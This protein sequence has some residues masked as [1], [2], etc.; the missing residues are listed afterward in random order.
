MLL[1]AVVSV[2]LVPAAGAADDQWLTDAERQAADANRQRQGDLRG[3]ID[4]LRASDIELEAESA[5]LDARTA[6]LLTS[7]EQLAAAL[8]DARLRAA[9]LTGEVERARQAYDEWQALAADRIVRAY[10]QPSLDMLAVVLS[11][12]DLTQAERR[13]TMANNV[14]ANDRRV[15]EE[16]RA[17]AEQLAVLEIEA[18]ANAEA[19]AS[20]AAQQ[21]AELAEL[22][23]ARVR[24]AEVERQ[25]EQR[26]SF[27]QA[28]V[29]GLA[30]SEADLMAIISQRQQAAA[31]TTTTTPPQTAPPT[32]TPPTTGGGSSG[33]GGGS[34]GGGGTA[35]PPNSPTPTSPP[36][37]SPPPTSP[38]NTGS[39]FLWPTNGVLTS[40]FGWRWGAMHQGIDIG[41][42]SGTP[43]Y[44]SN[45]GTVFYAGW[46]G[47]YG[48]LT[49]IDHGGGR[50]TAYAHQTGFAVTGGSVGRGQVIGYVG[51]TG[52]STGPHLHF[53]LRINGSAVDPLPY[54][55]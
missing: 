43:I 55:R 37:T 12:D 30:A 50:V 34:T 49:L 38:P 23:A 46:M 36:A 52:D 35:P 53:E 4:L 40:T 32:T 48:N 39:S 20:S 11:A 33:G 7:T 18:A 29:A 16:R 15:L 17:A 47:G 19:I 9:S 6:E 14:A 2:S 27:V 42:G 8:E 3:Q 44:A 22:R 24:A 25:L 28:E 26:I 13:M 45:A 51:S 21:E 10:M 54:L 1:A 31:A 41:A 5:R